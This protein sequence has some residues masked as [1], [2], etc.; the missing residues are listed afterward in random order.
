M[1]WWYSIVDK[2]YGDPRRR[3]P[4]KGIEGR[5][6]GEGMIRAVFSFKTIEGET[7]SKYRLGEMCGIT[8]KERGLLQTRA[9]RRRVYLEAMK[10]D[11]EAAIKDPSRPRFP[12]SPIWKN[13]KPG[14]GGQSDERI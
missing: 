6:F 14:A 3:E 7:M 10:G 12:V 1:I 8:G 2:R 11:S 5:L 13:P 9:M 4:Y